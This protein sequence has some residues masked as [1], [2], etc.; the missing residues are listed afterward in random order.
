MLIHRS[1]EELKSIMEETKSVELTTEIANALFGYF[2][3]LYDLNRNILKL[4]ASGSI[5][6]MG[7]YTKISYD[8]IQA[9][10]RLVPYRQ[11]NKKLE[12]SDDEGVLCFSNN[13]PFLENNYRVLFNNN[14][15]FLSTIKCL[16]NKLEHNMHSVKLI[17]SNQGSF[18]LFSIE[19]S[20]KNDDE[21]DKTLVLSAASLIKLVK[22]INCIFSKIQFAIS[23][24]V[25]KNNREKYWYYRRLLSIDFCDFNELFDS[26]L[27]RSVGKILYD[28]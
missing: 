28:F 3:L 6:D 24:F 8:A 16:R 21:C 20:I 22:E 12:L 1:N 23:V 2:E 11:I 26:K 14:V 19:Y 25:E 5:Y 4:C 15:S 13:L 9:I 7:Q 27:I 18:D 17:A 10:P